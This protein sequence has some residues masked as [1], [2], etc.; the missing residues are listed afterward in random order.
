MKNKF[1]VIGIALFLSMP[2]AVQS[3]EYVFPTEDNPTE[4]EEIAEID[5][6]PADKIEESMP[7]A[8]QQKMTF[9]KPISKRKL[10]KK[11][12]LAMFAVG[13]SSLILYVGLSLYNR[14]HEN[15]MPKV[16]TPEGE[17]PLSTPA[18]LESAVK[19]F[20]DKTDW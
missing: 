11:F 3:E 18:D 16:K 15:T 7:I 12:I 5:V 19:S 6:V 14:I 20:L 1:L 9:K 2:V 10:L 8:Q 4:I 13:V 17:T